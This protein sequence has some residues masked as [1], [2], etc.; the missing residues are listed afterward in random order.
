MNRI[1]K[2]LVSVFTLALVLGCF[3]PVAFANREI[4][5]FQFALTNSNE[6]DQTGVFNTYD[7]RW[8][9]KYH[10]YTPAAINCSA[11]YYH[12]YNFKSTLNYDN[13]HRATTFVWLHTAIRMTPYYVNGY[14][15]AGQTFE[16][17]ARR[18]NRETS[19]YSIAL[20]TW[21]PDDAY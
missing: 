13:P 2:V 21:S 17:W 14:G 8:L 19:L 9:E 3:A 1:K 18:D 6:T 11:Y 12:T 10:S 5:D 16:L 4:G 15:A 20:G 7:Q